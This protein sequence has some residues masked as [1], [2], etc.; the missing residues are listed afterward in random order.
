MEH[1]RWSKEEEDLLMR[2]YGTHPIEQIAKKLGKTVGA[3]LNKRQR[4]KL[5]AFLGNGDYIT[6]QD[7]YKQERIW[8]RR[9]KIQRRKLSVATFVASWYLPQL[10]V[11]GRAARFTWPI[12]RNANILSR[13]FGIAY[14]GE[15]RR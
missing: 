10:P 11:P 15:M 8:R 9:L 13:Y 6:R 7:L 5:G 2:W 12:V 14:T 4:L 3:V 1:K